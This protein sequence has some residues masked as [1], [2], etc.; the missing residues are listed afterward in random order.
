[1]DFPKDNNRKNIDLANYWDG[2]GFEALIGYLYLSDN[3][4]RLEE[5]ISMVFNSI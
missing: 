2:T 3:I 5:I 1:M 4:T